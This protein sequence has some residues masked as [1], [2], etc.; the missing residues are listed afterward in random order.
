MMTIIHSFG[1]HS[2]SHSFI[3]GSWKFSHNFRAHFPRLS[4]SLPCCPGNGK[5][6][7][8]WLDGKQQPSRSLNWCR[9]RHTIAAYGGKSNHPMEG[10][11]GIPLL[12]IIDYQNL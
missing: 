4:L 9:I 1:H 10:A 3:P 2:F 8:K 5:P 11:I 7:G 6:L 12:K